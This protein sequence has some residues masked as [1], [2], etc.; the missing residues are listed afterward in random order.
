MVKSTP[1]LKKRIVKKRTL[2]FTRFQSDLYGG[3]LAESWRRPRGNFRNMQALITEWEEDSEVIRKCPKSDTDQTTLPS[4]I[5][6]TD[7]KNSLSTTPKISMSFS[8]TTE[9]SAPKSPTT[10]A[11]AYLL[12]NKETCIDRKACPTNPCQGDQLSRQGQNW[13]KKTGSL[14]DS[15]LFKFI[16]D[17]MIEI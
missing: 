6:Q 2:K 13:I 8:W 16:F 12:H 4:T 5:F 15:D 17:S 3:R 9:P 1:L 7:S 10:S 11:P 14:I